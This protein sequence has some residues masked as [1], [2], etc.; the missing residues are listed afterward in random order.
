MSK[1]FKDLYEDSLKTLDLKIGAILQGEVISIDDDFVLIDSGLKSESLVSIKQFQDIDGEL[2]VK[3]GDK[4]AVA[5]TAVED[6]FGETRISRDKAKRA[7]MWKE[8]EVSFENNETVTGVIIGK[9]RG[10]LTVDINSVKAFLPGSLIDV[11]P[12]KDVHLDVDDRVD[13]KIVKMDD[14]FNNV[15]VSR[16]AI[17]EES[18]SVDRQALLDN[19]R[20]GQTVSGYV[21]NLTDYGAFVDLGGIDGLLHITDIS[22]RRIRHPKEILTLGQDVQVKVLTFDQEKQRVS[23]GLK[24]LTDDPWTALGKSVSV[25]DVLTGKVSSIADYGCFVNL[26]EGLEGLVH[27]SEMDWANKNINPHKFVEVGQ[28]VKVKVLEVDPERR[29]VSLGMKQCNENPWESF[30]MQHQVGDK[31][32]GVIKST[33]DFGLFIE[34]PGSIDGLIHLSDLSWD[35]PG[36]D[37]VREYK[38]GDEVEAVILNIDSERERISLGI[39]QLEKDPFSVYVDME[40]KDKA[41]KAKVTVVTEKGVEVELEDKAKG[42]IRISELSVDRVDD[43]RKQFSV[44]DDVEAKF[45]G[46]DRKN[47]VLNLSI[48]ALHEKEEQAARAKYS[49]S[50]KADQAK[51]SGVKTLG[52]LIKE[53]M[54]KEEKPA[55]KDAKKDAK[56]ESKADAKTDSKDKAKSKAEPKTKDDSETK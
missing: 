26:G 55:A 20:E 15:V 2:T 5:L 27:V 52:D 41:L 16:K 44:G 22:W 40:D 49:Q 18:T 32:K 8:L 37:L 34:L 38:Q 39:K 31:I 28:E 53:K 42:Y 11:R 25:G 14:K 47:N 51:A 46:V 56:K 12:L 19:L 45:V 30:S 29:R 21:K 13:V 9:V 10:G 17:I 33:T 7:E 50:K 48:R 6:S 23:L 24:Q 1:G 36:E 43:P 54:S 35:K 3:V 4:V